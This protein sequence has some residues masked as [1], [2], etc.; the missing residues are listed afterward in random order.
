MKKLIAIVTIT[1]FVLAFG[2]AYA[3]FDSLINTLDPSSVP[4]YVDPETGAATLPAPQALFI[5]RG[6]AAGGMSTAPDTF[7]NYINPSRVPGYV[8]PETGVVSTGPTAFKEF[9][10]SA[11][12]G[13]RIEPDTFLNYIDP[14]RISGY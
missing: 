6:S 7:M 8:D 11:A 13:A 1:G 14:S 12:G 10:G 4:G 2:T 3:E 5:D 9:R